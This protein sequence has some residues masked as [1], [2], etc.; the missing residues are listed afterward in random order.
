[1]QRDDV[2]FNSSITYLKCWMSPSRLANYN[3][4][5]RLS[6]ISCAVAQGALWAEEGASQETRN[7]M[8]ELCETMQSLIIEHLTGAFRCIDWQAIDA[9]EY[10]I[11]SA[12][13]YLRKLRSGSEDLAEAC[14]PCPLEPLSSLG[15]VINTNRSCVDLLKLFIL[16]FDN[17]LKC[18]AVF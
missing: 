7:A 12:C 5:C 4:Y 13:T 15:S 16:L 11:R 3:L 18:V 10:A 9:T 6:L 8:E 1:M 17:I 2:T 14:K